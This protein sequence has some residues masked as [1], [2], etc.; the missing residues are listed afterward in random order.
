MLQGLAIAFD[1]AGAQAFMAGQHLV[2]C[3]LQGSEVK[4]AAQF[5]RRRNMVGR[6]LWLQLPEEPL[7]LLGVGQRQWLATVDAAQ[8]GVFVDCGLSQR[9]AQGF[10]GVVLEQGA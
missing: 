6:A 1:E 4:L 5:Q 2:E 3:C 9:Q 8:C 7:A 10:K